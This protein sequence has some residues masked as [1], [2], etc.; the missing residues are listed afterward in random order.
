M[1]AFSFSSFAFQLPLLLTLSGR[2]ERVEKAER[3][4]KDQVITPGVDATSLGWML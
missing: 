4:V 3:E 1:V 2:Q